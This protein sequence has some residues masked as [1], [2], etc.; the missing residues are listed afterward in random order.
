MQGVMSG[1]G[2]IGFSVSITQFLSALNSVGKDSGTLNPS[3]PGER[4]NDGHKLVSSTYHFLVIS[5][6][7]TVIAGIATYILINL[8]CYEYAMKRHKQIEESLSQNDGNDTITHETYVKG[9]QHHNSSIWQVNR[10]IRDLGC[11]LAY[12]FIVSIGLFPGITV[13]IASTNT[14]SS[15]ASVRIRLKVFL[16]LS[17]EEN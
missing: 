13:S 9:Q 4:L 14:E 3:I 10:K 5:L 16:C 12:I 7:F 15:L 11:A 17:G 8:P 2:A 1:Q 6:L